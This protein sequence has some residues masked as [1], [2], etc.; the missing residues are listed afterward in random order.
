MKLDTLIPANCYEVNSRPD[1]VAIFSAL[2]DSPIPITMRFSQTDET[3]TCLLVA[4]NP[5]FEE[6]VF[7]ASGFAQVVAQLNGS[8]GLAATVQI[9]AVWFSFEALNAVAAHGY[10]H[11]AFRAR[12]PSTISRMQRRESIRYPVPAFNSPVCDVPMKEGALRLRVVDISLSGI[13]LATEGSIAGVPIGSEFENCV[14]HLPEIG[15]IH[16]GL[17]VAYQF[18]SGKASERRMGCRFS[19]MLASSLSHLQRYIRRLERDQV[20]AGEP[21]E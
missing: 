12:M 18:S 5:S 21:P 7:D 15:A 3:L 20:S 8:G 10:P 9:N 6:L 13:A 14:L 17:V 11:P 4:V 16:S 19:N 1:V 2:V